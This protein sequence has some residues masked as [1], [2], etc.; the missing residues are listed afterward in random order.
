MKIIS[1]QEYNALMDYMK[2]KLKSL[3]N[4]ENEEREKLGKEL[5]NMFQFGFPI[6]DIN[7][8]GINENNDFY[9]VFNGSFLKMINSSIFDATTEYPNKFGTGDAKD[10]IDALYNTSGYK[11]WGTKQDYINFLTEH[12]CCYIVYR[13]NGVFSDIL[14]IDMLRSTMPNK[15]NPT[16]IDFVGGLLHT[17]KHFSI[18]DQNLS[19]GT[20]VYNVF[21]IR[22]IV[23]LIGMAFRLK[24]GEGTKYK[25]LQELTNAIMLASFYKEEVTGIFFLNSY[26]KKKSI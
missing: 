17:L 5:I 20:Y 16:K 18:K 12:A 23:Y 6:S 15:E 11:Y 10:V 19:T 24:N 25:S 13:D 3:W 9:I 7:R 14:R 22:H 4:H 21:D 1:I 8:H 2:S 26:Y